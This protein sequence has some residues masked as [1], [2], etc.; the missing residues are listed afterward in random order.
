VQ[1]GQM[2]QRDGLSIGKCLPKFCDFCQCSDG[3]PPHFAAVLALSARCILVFLMAPQHSCFTPKCFCCVHITRTI[4]VHTPSVL[5]KWEAVPTQQDGSP[6]PVS[7]FPVSLDISSTVAPR[8]WDSAEDVCPGPRVHG[9]WLL[10]G[11]N[12]GHTY[13]FND[14][15]LSPAICLG[16]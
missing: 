3:I 12:L 7:P 8:I 11:V 6:S 13:L 5:P 15:G 16:G 1:C 2:A 9:E 10:T 14:T 4:S